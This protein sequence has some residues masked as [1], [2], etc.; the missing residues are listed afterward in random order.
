[1]ADKNLT[2][3][4]EF[5]DSVYRAYGSFVDY[6]VANHGN[7][8]EVVLIPGQDGLTARVKGEFDEFKIKYSF[9]EKGEPLEKYLL[10]FDIS[11]FGVHV[12]D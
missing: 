2:K 3:P 4:V 8:S 12:L 10:C 9:V 7:I 6:L 5:P 11:K 1:M